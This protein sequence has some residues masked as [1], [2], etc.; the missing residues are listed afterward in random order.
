MNTTTTLNIESRAATTA[1]RTAGWITDAVVNWLRSIVKPQ[2]GN[3]GT[4]ADSG[5][6]SQE[7]YVMYREDMLRGPL[8]DEF[9]RAP[10]L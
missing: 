6:S 9:R 7:R 4:A 3:P 2:A 8:S 10:W 5:H 1:T